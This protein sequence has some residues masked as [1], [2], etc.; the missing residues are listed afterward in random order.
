VGLEVTTEGVNS[1]MHSE[2]WSETVLNC[3]DETTGAKRSA[4]IKWRTKWYVSQWND[5]HA[6]LNGHVF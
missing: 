6:K 1:G 3:N 2:R 5:E 4:D